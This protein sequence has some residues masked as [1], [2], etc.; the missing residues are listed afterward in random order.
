MK[1]K[2]IKAVIGFM[3]SAVL[4]AVCAI[5]TGTMDV[6]PDWLPQVCDFA[7]IVASCLGIKVTIPLQE[8]EKPTEAK[9]FSGKTEQLNSSEGI[10]IT[11][12]G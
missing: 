7:S 9:Q 2:N 11:Q 8:V 3:L 12:G 5:V 1:V 10:G 4:F 6:A